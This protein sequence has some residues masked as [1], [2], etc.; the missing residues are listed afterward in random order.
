M[1]RLVIQKRVTATKA[2]RN[3]GELY[4]YN[5]AFLSMP[6]ILSS[7]AGCLTERNEEVEHGLEALENRYGPVLFLCL[8][9]RKKREWKKKKKIVSLCL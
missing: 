1:L 7:Q 4:C 5:S 9:S 6:T 2:V 8:L 3:P